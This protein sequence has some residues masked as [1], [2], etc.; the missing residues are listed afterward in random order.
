MKTRQHSI[1]TSVP[2]PSARLDAAGLMLLVASLADAANQM[3]DKST[4]SIDFRDVHVYRKGG[5]LMLAAAGH[6]RTIHRT[7][8]GV[9]TM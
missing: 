3:A 6:Q 7:P 9:W 8:G 4:T 2:V 5:Q 1:L